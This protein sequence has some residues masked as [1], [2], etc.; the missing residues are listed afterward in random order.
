MRLL[1][2]SSQTVA[3]DLDT[4]LRRDGGQ[5][6]CD[7]AMYAVLDVRHASRRCHQVQQ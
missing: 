3:F 1:Q 5:S 6:A 4:R 7:G 2:E